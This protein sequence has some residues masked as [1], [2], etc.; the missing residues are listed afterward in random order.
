M[1]NFQNTPIEGR[2]ENL[3]MFYGLG[4]RSMQLTYNERNDSA[5][6]RRSA[7]MRA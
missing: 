7:P 5:T 3:D 2:L 6:A 4:V 1:F